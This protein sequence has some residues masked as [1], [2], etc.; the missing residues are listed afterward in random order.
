MPS[1]LGLCYATSQYPLLVLALDTNSNEVGFTFQTPLPLSVDDA[2]TVSV[3]LANDTWTASG[4]VQQQIAI[5]NA[6]N[7]PG[8]SFAVFKEIAEGVASSTIV[9]LTPSPDAGTINTTF[10]THPGYA[11]A[12]QS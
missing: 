3:S 1:G 10:P 6:P 11:S 12:V 5:A 4:A 7:V 2:G 8:Q 9:D